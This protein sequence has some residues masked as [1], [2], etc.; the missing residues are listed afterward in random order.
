MTLSRRLRTL[1][2]ALTLA[3]LAATAS[4]QAQ[5]PPDFHVVA[6]GGAIDPD[7]PVQIVIVDST[8]AG[9]FC[10]IEGPDRL[11]ADCTTQVALALGAAELD[12]VWSAVQ[13]FGFFG[14]D[15]TYLDTTFVGG[16]WAELEVTGAGQSHRVRT[17]NTGVAGVDSV[18]VA[19]NEVLPAGNKIVYNE[20]VP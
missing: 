4:L 5:A 17:Q 9:A 10:E 19:L 15:S 20:I 16:S 7:H 2:V 6:Q 13:R 3:F 14:L 18:M 8:G 1:A 11:T 12:S